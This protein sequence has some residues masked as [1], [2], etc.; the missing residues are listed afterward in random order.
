MDQP[1]RS[2]NKSADRQHAAQC[3]GRFSSQ[4]GYS[5][6]QRKTDDFREGVKAAA[7]RRVPNVSGR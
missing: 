5:R 2:P 7:E 3:Y 1:S 4:A 6:R